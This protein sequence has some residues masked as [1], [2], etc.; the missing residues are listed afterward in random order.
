MHSQSARFFLLT[1]V[2]A[3]GSVACTQRDRVNG[4]GQPSSALSLDSLRCDAVSEARGCVLYG[5]SLY[6]LIANPALFHGK[7]VRVIGFAHFEFEGNALYA[8]REDWERGILSNGIW[9]NPPAGMDSLSNDY[10]IVEARFNA[11]QRGHM[12]MWSGSLDSVTRLERWKIPSVT[13]QNYREL[14]QLPSVTPRE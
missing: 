1:L 14:R 5:V 6:E 12:G 10:V 2:C 13:R 3:V 4:G 8:H 7:R 9:M 11:T